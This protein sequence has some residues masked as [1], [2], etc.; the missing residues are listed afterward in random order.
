MAENKATKP[1]AK[2]TV[3]KEVEKKHYSESSF[4]E[5]IKLHQKELD[6]N[7]ILLLGSRMDMIRRMI[8]NGDLVLKYIRELEKKWD[9]EELVELAKKVGKKI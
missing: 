8:P 3:K 5:F 4:E 9:A 1:A 6:S 7:P 2:K